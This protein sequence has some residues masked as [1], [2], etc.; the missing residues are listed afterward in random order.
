MWLPLLWLEAACICPVFLPQEVKCMAP[1]MCWCMLFVRNCCV[2]RKPGISEADRS[3]TEPHFCPFHTAD[4]GSHLTFPRPES[5][6]V[7]WAQGVCPC[8]APEDEACLQSIRHRPAKWLMPN[9]GK[10]ILQLE[11][12]DPHLGLRSS[13]GSS[14]HSHRLWVEFSSRVRGSG[15]RQRLPASRG[16]PL[17]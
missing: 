10:C 1:S 16:C 7:Q 14:S 6:C 4:S 13:P 11:P 8:W 5:L 9:Q 2:K 15:G 3:R 17:L 12:A